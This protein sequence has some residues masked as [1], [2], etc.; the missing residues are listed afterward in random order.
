[1]WAWIAG[2]IGGPREEGRLGRSLVWGEEPSA[3]AA[4]KMSRRVKVVM[5]FA[6]ARSAVGPFLFEGADVLLDGRQQP[7]LAPCCRLL[8]RLVREVQSLLAG[9][10]PGICVGKGVEV[11]RHVL[12]LRPEGLLD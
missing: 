5:S 8:P 7:G 2:K 4:I 12:V 11:A 10:R 6:A 1:M 3:R 9:T